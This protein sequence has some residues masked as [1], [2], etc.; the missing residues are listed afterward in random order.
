MS[1]STGF[2]LLQDLWPWVLCKRRLC[3]ATA[4][5]VLLLSTVA[6]F[7]QGTSLTFTGTTAVGKPAQ[8][9]AVTLTMRAAGQ[10]AAPTALTGGLP[11]LDFSV[12]DPG[13]CTTDL[14]VVVGQTC[15]LQVGFTPRFP[16][17]R[18]GA[19]Q[20]LST[21]GHTVLATAP[22]SGLAQGGLPVLVPGEMNTVAGDGQWIYHGDGV[23]ATSAPIFLPNG[24]AVD[25][26]G[27][28]FLSDSSNNRVRRVDAS[29]GIITT[30]AGNGTAGYSGDNG[31]ATQA[32]VNNPSGL[33]LDG[34]GNLY[35]ADS[36]NSL[37][38][39][40]DAVTGVITTVAGA[41]D[42]T[43][44]TGDG[45][46]GTSATLTSPQGLALTP[47]GDLLIADSGNAAVRLL[48]INSGR[49]TTIAGTGTPGYNGDGI[50]A[51]TAQLNEPWGVA[52]RA[53]GAVAVADLSNHRIRLITPSGLISTVAGTGYGG[54]SGDNAPASQAQLNGPAAVAFD[55]AGDLLIADAGNNR[56]R[57]V[58]GNPGVITTLTGTASE[59]FAGDAGPAN[60]ASLYG[61]YALVFD[62]M[63]NIWI[64]DVFHNR[65]RKISVSALNIAYSP[66]RV[67]KTSSPVLEMLYNAGNS[68]LT[69]SAPVLQQ[70]ALDPATTTCNT[71]AMSPTL[72]CN[73]GVEFAPTQVGQSITGSIQWPSD[74]PNVT[75]ADTL[76]GQV[77]SVE[78]TSTA[79]VADANPGLLGK[80]LTLTATVTSA[81]TGRSGTVTFSEGPQVWCNNI[82]LASDSTATC[83]IPSLSLGTHTFTAAYSG[84]D[85]NAA[86]T[87]TAY[88][89]TIKQQAA[90]ALAVS[91]AQA[92]VTGAVTLTFTAADQ[93][94]IPTGTVVF[95]DGSTAL[96]SASLDANG[97]ATWRTGTLSIGT[98]LLS[99]G[100]AGDSANVSGTSS[101][102]TEQI[103]QA[104]TATT[105]AV[106]DASPTVGSGIT[107][108]A[109]VSSGNGPAPTGSVQFNDGTGSAAVPLGNASL[110]AN[111]TATFS[112]ATLSP[113]THTIYATYSGDTDSA[114]SIS[115][116]ILETV[117][118]IAT[119][120][121]VSTDVNP[122]N[123]EATLHLSASV[124]LVPGAAADGALTGQISFFD[125]SKLLG[126]AA[127]NAS[128]QATLALSTLSVG[129]H[130]ISADFLGSTN[131]ASSTSP[132]VSQNVQRSGTQ[133]S[134]T[135]NSA[136]SLAG[137][138]VTLQATVTGVT[139]T[140]SGTVS[141]RD[142]SAQLGTA[143]L[144]ANGTASLTTASL[145][146]AS[147][148]ITAVYAGDANFTASTSS[149]VQQTVQLA[150]PVLTLSGPSTPVNAGTAVQL[151]VN[152][153]SPGVP[154]TGVLT[155]ED[156]AI[157]I[158]TLS[159]NSNGSYTFSIASLALG[160]HTLTI[161][162]AGDAENAAAS[163]SPFTL[164]VQQAPTATALITSINPLTQGT[165]LTLTATTTSPSA[166]LSGQ[167]TFYDGP[168]RLGS[169][170][171]NAAGSAAITVSATLSLG[172]HPL[173][174]TYSGDTVHAPS[175]STALSELVV[176]PST[177]TLTSSNNPSASGQNV[178]FTA[179]FAGIGVIPTGTASFRDGGTLLATVPLTATGVANYPTAGLSVGNHT[180]TCTYNGDPNYA[181]ATAQLLQTVV[182]ADTQVTLQA[183][184]NPAIYGQPL[185]LSTTVS[186]NGGAATGS[187]SFLADGISLG[188][189]ALNNSQQAV[190]S[191]STLAPGN[192]VLSARYLGNSVTDASVSAPL[193]L[194]V[195]QNTTL[196]LSSSSN[197][198]PTLNPIN[199]TATLSN[200][201]ATTATG[202][203]T[204]L[205]GAQT[206][207]TATPD[208]SG[209]AS[210]PLPQL[211]A[212]QHTLTATYAGDIAD[213][214]SSAAPLLQIVQL[215]PTVTTV[216]GSATDPTNPQQVT[217][218][219]VV[220]G[221]VSVPP[222]GT[223][224]FTAGPLTLGV[225]Q[226]DLTGVATLTVLFETASQQVEASYAG[227]A[228]Y[229]ASQSALTGITA[230]QAAQ[231][232]LNV[233]S[234]SLALVTK[235]HATVTV[236]LGS[237]KGF[238]DR[239]VLGCEGLP[240]AATCTFNTSQLT[241]AADGT[242]SATLVVDTGDP[243]GAGSSASAALR[244]QPEKT[245]L[246]WLPAGALLLLCSRRAR[247]RAGKAGRNKLTA[248]LLLVFTLALAM[249]ATGCSGLSISGTPPGSYSFK[250]VATGQGSG[251]TQTQTV[252]LVVTQ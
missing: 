96:G 61:P 111:G 50:S 95:Y 49:I 228:A 196:S 121:A 145:A 216:T 22:L 131:Y 123:A 116:P 221:G 141:F 177:A 3:S 199:L 247:C 239:I 18:Q 99:V 227:D 135:T 250:V 52:S 62:P 72:F 47:S 220:R 150:Q 28:L 200:A 234:A 31:P 64:S 105:L 76:S 154:P 167:V 7:A 71:S 75:P 213:L 201:G 11:N 65:V 151:L 176:E 252:T 30:V 184:A 32:E 212:G 189:A 53:D 8:A 35:I 165:T 54:F 104:T 144:D 169:S 192:H 194:S 236:N 67:G 37:I 79:L 186:S 182:N 168:T 139:G 138:P 38:R 193:S 86:G 55:P 178:A 203:V 120:T 102:V 215:R 233:S 249:G 70:A 136:I 93:T 66:M 129:T 195:K 29:T 39:R 106:S 113:G 9:V 45:G 16:G 133:T 108:T 73:M 80:P 2:I 19:V 58:Y 140:P 175:T 162:Y 237:V 229:A 240:Y 210:L 101:I 147:H 74:A 122:A 231:F 63:G 23:L 78:P 103:V 180:I 48:T 146:A 14:P 181:V 224:S 118:Q 209:H 205:D 232:T 110:T 251:T 132:T 211:T 124:S 117:G 36:S 137:K 13:T 230:G 183:S 222:S 4:F 57:G 248:L 69:L 107:L 17:I 92:V 12:A 158:S 156:G 161:A 60:Q 217:L 204:F 202:T 46:P 207:G 33:V 179:V 142:G 245:T 243:L 34:A 90:L 82:A 226:V 42:T 127:I 157:A 172:Q 166:N 143:T 81:D 51:I 155:L 83:T 26:A 59:E 6:V 159:L 84:D 241:L 91:P 100:Y 242:A 15:T 68:D 160:T 134:L 235:Q 114:T 164:E 10:A 188:T 40:V 25:A 174:A 126:T 87:S 56:V 119:V 149:A 190:F 152:L 173:T 208:A 20:L 163:S 171:L 115:V 88:T 238:S 98:H 43:G 27:N 1:R 244:A 187:V 97:A 94:G 185:T 85:N 197:P 130:A 148:T 198:S 225:A 112:T 41:A 219:A 218:I 5:F 44:Y 246:C 206:L 77:L 109:N 214:P 21:D 153:S 128:G 125:G 24:L 223:V 89:E 170:I 191:T